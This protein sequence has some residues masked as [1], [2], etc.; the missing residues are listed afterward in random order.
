MTRIINRDEGEK[1]LIPKIVQKI[2]LPK[3]RVFK[4]RRNHLRNLVLAAFYQ[5]FSA[6]NGKLIGPLGPN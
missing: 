6:D 5:K 2:D 1:S 3:I 4:L